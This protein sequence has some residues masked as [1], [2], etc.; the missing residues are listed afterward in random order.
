MVVMQLTLLRL[1]SYKI[2]THLNTSS[3]FQVLNK[4]DS[5]LIN[6]FSLSSHVIYDHS[7]D[8]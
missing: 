5:S 8:Y 4:I 1:Y 2:D 7:K 6:V 3:Y